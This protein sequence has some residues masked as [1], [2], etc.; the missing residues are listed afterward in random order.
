MVISVADVALCSKRYGYG[1]RRGNAVTQRPQHARCKYSRGL[2]SHTKHL[3]A[4]N[5]LT[6]EGA[7]IPTPR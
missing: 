7:A 1:E 3:N 6:D 4:L 2:M 5:V